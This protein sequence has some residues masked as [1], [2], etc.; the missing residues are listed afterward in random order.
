MRLPR[1]LLRRLLAMIYKIYFWEISKLET[2]KQKSWLNY[3]NIFAISLPILLIIA[4]I[5]LSAFGG[6]GYFILFV[7]TILFNFV[8]PPQGNSAW[9]LFIAVALLLLL[10][11]L[12][13]VFVGLLS[14]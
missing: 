12:S 11:P 7:V 13:L 4:G 5:A 8:A 6:F 10:C 3:I 2:M 9:S 14:R 1:R